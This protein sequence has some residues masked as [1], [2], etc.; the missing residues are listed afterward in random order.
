MQAVVPLPLIGH[1]HSPKGVAA[2]AEAAGQDGILAK[3]PTLSMQSAGGFRFGILFMGRQIALIQPPVCV[4]LPP[5][6]YHL[7]AKMASRGPDAP[8]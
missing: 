2:S 5:V 6:A 3:S 4:N 8:L 7:R 1:V